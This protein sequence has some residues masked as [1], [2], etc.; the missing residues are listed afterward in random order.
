MISDCR[1]GNDGINF[2]VNNNDGIHFDVNNNDVDVGDER[3]P[4]RR[5]DSRE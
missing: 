5:K 3:L 1:N 2:D 4:L